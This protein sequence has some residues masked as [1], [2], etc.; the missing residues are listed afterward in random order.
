MRESKTMDTM[1]KFGISGLVTLDEYDVEDWRVYFQGQL[2]V[3][4]FTNRFAAMGYLSSLRSGN[5]KPVFA[6]AYN[7]KE[8]R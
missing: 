3:P 2:T 6:R 4:K 1:N 7:G 8:V 5:S